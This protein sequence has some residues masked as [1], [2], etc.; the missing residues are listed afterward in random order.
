MQSPKLAFVLPPVGLL[1]AIGLLSWGHRIQ[2]PVGMD[3]IFDPAPI[4]ICQGIN[5]PALI[6]KGLM[7]LTPLQVDQD[8]PQPIFSFSWSELYFLLG[9]LVLWYLVGRFFDT[10]SH[11]RTHRGSAAGKNG[12]K[13]LTAIFLISIMI[14]GGVLFL[15]TLYPRDGYMWRNAAGTIEG[16]LF[17]MWSTALIVMSTVKFWWMWGKRDSGAEV[18]D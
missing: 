10:C 3:T 4:L 7:T 11:L 2:P 8:P 16:L 17:R 5:A 6:F 18:M 14:W 13:V 15:E 1:T 12:T 9:V